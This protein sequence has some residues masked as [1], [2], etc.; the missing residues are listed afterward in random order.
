MCKNGR[1]GSLLRDSKVHQIMVWDRRGTQWTS[2]IRLF[3]SCPRCERAFLSAACCTAWT[4]EKE[5]SVFKHVHRLASQQ[6][7]ANVPTPSLLFAA[8]RKSK[9]RPSTAR[10]R[11]SMK[12]FMFSGARNE[13]F[14]FHLCKPSTG[15]PWSLPCGWKDP[16]PNELAPDILHCGQQSGP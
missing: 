11:C 13:A 1:F 4:N 2:I 14:L 9:E 8:Y 15:S 16:V 6:Q 3:F 10:L 5:S 7:F 12:R